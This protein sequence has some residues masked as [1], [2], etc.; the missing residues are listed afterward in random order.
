ML[1]QSNCVVD[2]CSMSDSELDQLRQAGWRGS[3]YVRGSHPEN[4]GF[5]HALDGLRRTAAD[6]GEADEAARCDEF[7]HLLDPDWDRVGR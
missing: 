3:G 2:D 6:I 4:V 7:L 1:D 5:L